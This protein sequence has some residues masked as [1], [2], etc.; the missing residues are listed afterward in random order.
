MSAAQP[1]GARGR[2]ARFYSLPHLHTRRRLRP[3]GPAETV[4]R[5]TVILGK[6]V[7]RPPAPLRIAG[8]SGLLL[9]ASVGA[10]GFGLISFI[11]HLVHVGTYRTRVCA[12]VRRVQEN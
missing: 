6:V 5:T 7:V 1:R 10:R 12:E 2:S 9:G 8:M 4:S 11:S 3:W